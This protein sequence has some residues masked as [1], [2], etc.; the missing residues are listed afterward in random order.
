MIGI[1]MGGF[2][3]LVAVGTGIALVIVG[4][5]GGFE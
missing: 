3:I 2:G 1:V 4:L 5:L